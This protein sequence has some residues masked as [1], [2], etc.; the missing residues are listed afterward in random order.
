MGQSTYPRR[1][2]LDAID[3]GEEG[4]AVEE[5]AAVAEAD[6]EH[7]EGEMAEAAPETTDKIDLA[8]VN[9]NGD[10]AAMAR[11]ASVGAAFEVFNLSDQQD[12]AAELLQGLDVNSV[13]K[14]T[15]TDADPMLERLIAM[16]RRALGEE[17]SAKDK[18]VLKAVEKMEV[19][20]RAEAEKGR[21]DLL[22][23][24]ATAKKDVDAQVVQRAVQEGNRVNAEREDRRREKQR[25]SKDDRASYGPVTKTRKGRAQPSDR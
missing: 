8:S 9:V 22:A 16:K 4:E 19:A 15:T 11:A 5:T 20:E 21:D 3:K 14:A 1:H 7:S 24:L 13:S 2:K 23:E 6:L 25:Q 10:Y 12:G 17:L 18:E